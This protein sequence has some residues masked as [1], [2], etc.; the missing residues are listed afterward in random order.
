M[1]SVD[2][3]RVTMRDCTTVARARGTPQSNFSESVKLSWSLGLTITGNI[4]AIVEHLG[5][6]WTRRSQGFIRLSVAVMLAIRGISF[7]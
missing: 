2:K 5:T 1:A 6:L 3:N 7:G 4:V